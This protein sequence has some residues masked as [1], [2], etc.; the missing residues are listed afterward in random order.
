MSNIYF[1]ESGK[2]IG[3]GSNTSKVLVHYTGETYG[4]G[5]VFYTNVA[6]TTGYIA[7]LDDTPLLNWSCSGSCVV[8]TK[9][10]THKGDFFI[11]GNGYNNTRLIW[12]KYSGETCGQSGVSLASYCWNLSLSGYSDWYMPSSAELDM[13]YQRRSIIPNLNLTGAD[14]ASST[15]LDDPDHPAYPNAFHVQNFSTG[16]RGLSWKYYNF[17]TRPIRSFGVEYEQISKPYIEDFKK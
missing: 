6:G 11:L 13:I 1:N 16:N 4:G 2:I 9:P 10:Q 8:G 7:A 3:N 5:V 15:D 14:Y 17:P 12:E